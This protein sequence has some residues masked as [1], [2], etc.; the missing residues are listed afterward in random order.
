MTRT[1][2]NPLGIRTLGP[3][4]LALSGTS[5]AEVAQLTHSPTISFEMWAEKSAKLGINAHVIQTCRDQLLFSRHQLVHMRRSLQKDLP[6]QRFRPGTLN[7]FLVSLSIFLDNE[8]A[9]NEQAKLTYAAE[10]LL[11]LSIFLPEEINYHLLSVHSEESAW[12]QITK[13]LYPYFTTPRKAGYVQS[14]YPPLFVIQTAFLPAMRDTLIHPLLAP[15]ETTEDLFRQ[16]QFLFNSLEFPFKNNVLSEK[17]EMPSSAAIR[18]DHRLALQEI[19]GIILFIREAS[20]EDNN[21]LS[22]AALVLPPLLKI[23]LHELICYYDRLSRYTSVP[24]HWGIRDQEPTPLPAL[25]AASTAL[26]DLP[27]L[28]EGVLPLFPDLNDL[29]SSELDEPP[30]NDRHVVTES[31]PVAI[32]GDHGPLREF[33]DF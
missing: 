19:L 26:Q 21:L 9:L 22:R 17:I 6:Q 2:S 24:D 23:S 10:L 11:S 4:S 31:G 32:N 15:G 8:T 5:P 33:I 1:I 12:G 29:T 25:K 14:L 30:F 7:M 13:T 18:E 28:D 27:D 20:I 3:S 16:I